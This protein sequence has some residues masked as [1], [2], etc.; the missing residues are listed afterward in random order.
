MHAHDFI[1]EMANR[2]RSR[3]FLRRFNRSGR[4]YLDLLAAPSH[5]DKYYLN[6]LVISKV[7]RYNKL[8]IIIT[9]SS[10]PLAPPIAPMTVGEACAAELFF[11]LDA[12]EQRSNG[13]ERILHAGVQL[14]PIASSQ[15]RSKISSPAAEAVEQSQSCAGLSLVTGAIEMVGLVVVIGVIGGRGE[16]VV[17]VGGPSFTHCIRLKCIVVFHKDHEEFHKTYS[18]SCKSM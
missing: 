16:T 3:T 11:R 2:C 13:E 15:Q 9:I 4:R 8:T 14:P 1:G 5:Q 17:V 7:I 12:K 10:S 6:F 18:V